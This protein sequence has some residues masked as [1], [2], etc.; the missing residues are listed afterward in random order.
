MTAKR[1]II[2]GITGASGATYALRTLEALARAGCEIHLCISEPGRRVMEIETGLHL[3]T[4]PSGLAK[5]INAPTENIHL[6][7]PDDFASAIC[8][9]SARFDGMA[10]V[11]CSMRTLG[12]IAC[13]CGDNAM[14][15]AADV[16]LKDR[17]PLILVPRETPLS[18]IHL[19]NMLELA[20]AGATVLP[21]CPGFYHKP[22][23]VAD[24]VDFVVARLLDALGVQNDLVKRW[25]EQ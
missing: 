17:R 21:A 6:I 10:V 23:S 1:K 15:R 3:P 20:R 9:G 22:Q 8:S 14:H 4:D 13:G 5:L 24:L 7:A 12:A 19:R 2:L 25:P 18:T 16:T 11:P